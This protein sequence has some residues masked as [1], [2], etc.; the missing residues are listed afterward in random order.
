MATAAPAVPEGVL[1]NVG[2]PEPGNISARPSLGSGSS[3]S[4]AKKQTPNE[5]YFGRTIGEGNFAKLRFCL[6]IQ[7]N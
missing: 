5:F 2:E 6:I 4:Q 1:I 3:N 7:S